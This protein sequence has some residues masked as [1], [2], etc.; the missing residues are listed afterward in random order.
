MLLFLGAHLPT[1][2]LNL[3]VQTLWDH[4]RIT[5]GH[6]SKE[7]HMLYLQCFY[8]GSLCPSLQKLPC[9]TLSA[10]SPK[11]TSWSTGPWF[12]TSCNIP[13]RYKI[14]REVWHGWSWVW[15]KKDFFFR[16]CICLTRWYGHAWSVEDM[17]VL[18][19][20]WL[21]GICNIKTDIHIS[22]IKH[23]R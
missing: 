6:A 22:T 17:F 21:V 16:D 18:Y 13:W 2:L 11:P 19:D 15:C 14:N 23:K 12:C 3:H 1:I 4:S 7:H 10:L 5:C 9:R 8:F 20:W